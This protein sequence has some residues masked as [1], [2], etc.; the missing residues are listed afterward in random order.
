M[1]EIVKKSI[2]KQICLVLCIALLPLPVFATGFGKL[3]VFSALGEPLNAEI[4]LL[5]VSPQELASLSVGLAS[6]E[7][8]A[9]QG[10]DKTAIQQNIKAQLSKKTG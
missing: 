7:Q 8:Y 4:E 3:S 6:Q 10:I 5:S 1:S 2:I 9:L